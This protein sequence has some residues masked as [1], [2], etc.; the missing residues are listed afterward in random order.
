VAKTIREETGK[1]RVLPIMGKV[2][3]VVPQFTV[4]GSFELC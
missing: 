3:V 1:K 2:V 4:F